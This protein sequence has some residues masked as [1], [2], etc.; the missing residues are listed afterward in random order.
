MYV[1]NDYYCIYAIYFKYDILKY[2]LLMIIMY[3]CHIFQIH[4]KMYVINDYYVRY[5][6]AQLMLFVNTVL[7]D[8]YNS[9]T[10]NF[11]S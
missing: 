10:H 4:F 9:I 11:Y 3:I 2:T 5:L 1:I 8:R 6:W 7:I